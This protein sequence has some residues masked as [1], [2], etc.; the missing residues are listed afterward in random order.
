MTSGTAHRN[1]RWSDRP[2]SMTSTV[3]LVAL[4]PLSRAATTS[5]TPPQSCVSVVTQQTRHRAVSN[6]V[7][8][9]V[10]SVPTLDNTSSA[11]SDVARILNR[12]WQLHGLL[13]CWLEIWWSHYARIQHNEVN[14]KCNFI[15]SLEKRLPISLILF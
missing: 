4:S 6:S 9:L 1:R 7:N 2:T 11:W 13:N 8:C 14:K 10:D 5:S 12:D 3:G 15:P